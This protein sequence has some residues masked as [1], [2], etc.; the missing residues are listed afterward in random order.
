MTPAGAPAWA[1]DATDDAG[2]RLRTAE[3]LIG[4]GRFGEAVPMLIQAERSFAA[5]NDAHARIEVLRAL[6]TAYRALGEPERGVMALERALPEAT[7]A[8]S[9][10]I[11]TAYLGS[12]S[13]QA[14]NNDRARTLLT[15]ALQSARAQEDPVLIAAI[16]NDLGALHR[17]ENENEQAL[18]LYEE[19][20]RLDLGADNTVV[21][22]E[23]LLNA[24]W[25]QL[26][27][28]DH[29]AAGALLLRAERAAQILNT[30]YRRVQG[31]TRTGQLL[32]ELARREPATRPQMVKTAH[33]LLQTASNLAR[34]MG[35]L[36]VSS[37]V[38]G[39]LGT[40][41]LLAGRLDDA[42]VLTR[43]AILAAQQ[44]GANQLLFR[45]HWQAGRIF[46]AQRQSEKA[47][48]S[49]RHAYAIY[50]SDS[51]ATPVPDD[52]LLTIE[53]PAVAL[54]ELADLLLQKSTT[55]NDPAQLRA[56]LIET[57]D[58]VEQ[59]KAQELQDYFRDSCIAEARARTRTVE[60]SMD[61]DTAVLYPIVFADRL[62]LLVSHGTEIRRV[63]VNISA[64]AIAEAAHRLRA[65]AEGR[66]TLGYLPHAQALYRWL[67]RPIEPLL[68]QWRVTTLVTVSDPTLRAMPF[69]ALHDGE[70]F[71]IDR[72]AV[73]TVPSLELTDPRPISTRKVK[74]L[75]V[76]LTESVQGYPAL[77]N[78]ESEL[79][80]IRA[81]Y[82]GPVIINDA[83]QRGRLERELTGERY[84]IAH[85]AS[86]GEFAGEVRR[87]F[88]LSY[89]G[90]ISMDELARYIGY[91]RVRD[92]PVDLLTLS[93][94]HTAAGD[95]RAALGLAGIAVK[96]GARSAL[97]SLWPIHDDATSLLMTEFYRQLRTHGVSKAEA[98]RRAQTKL[99]GMTRYRHPGYWSAFV[100]I[101]SW[102]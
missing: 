48:A 23:A 98:L 35:V 72:L 5:A 81:I 89:D 68:T 101:G 63:T 54:L 25:L 42:L 82:D 87:S 1:Q 88:I 100:L 97:A 74:T 77:V 64:D 85:I 10:T 45:W 99:L 49:Y 50:R 76:G 94:C 15:G 9:K 65:E 33:A 26:D 90:K 78:V 32:L 21:T 28:G 8:R 59:M 37:S 4:D 47:I 55:V 36:H 27:R 75:M 60:Q 24:A 83:F 86:H 3:K 79:E 58:V 52:I 57:R 31:A 66:H 13:L 96:A 91:N 38:D 14:G 18:A 16:L 11:L 43:E 17:G 46:H 92:D 40:T 39:T 71:L 61:P 73:A 56:Q 20:A 34:E 51:L 93:A 41:Y 29:A 22:L 30:P 69:A 95:E 19:A 62:E 44:A 6:A 7:D 12:L 67:V 53:S 80:N 70:R 102:R 2:N 84:N